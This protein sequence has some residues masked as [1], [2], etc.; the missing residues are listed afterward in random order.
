MS[1]KQSYKRVDTLE[2]KA[3]LTKRIGHHRADKYFDQLTRLIS[4]KTTKSEFDKSCARIVGRENIPL[5]NQLIR[6][7]IKNASLGKV[8]PPLG[9]IKRVPTTPN[10]KVLDRSSLQSLYGEAAFSPSTRKGRSPINRKFKDRPSPLG[11]LSSKPQN[12]LLSDEL[13]SRAQEQQQSATELLSLG[14]RP[15]PVDVASVEEGEEVEQFAGSPGVQSRCPVTAPF[16][17]SMNLGRKALS[18]LSLCGRATTNLHHGTCQN[19]GE[20]PDTRLLRNR[21]Q[22]K[23]QAEGMHVSL[24]CVNLLN[25]ALDAYLKRLVEPC[26]G[27]AACSRSRSGSFLHDAARSSRFTMQGSEGVSR[28]GSMLDFR[29]SAE[30]NPQMFGADWAVQLEKV[31]LRASEEW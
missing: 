13:I 30:S 9:S 18:N 8:P 1:S 16:G 19:S 11:P 26:L 28:S 17:I 27:L 2:I 25:N 21:L 15:P 23:L 22:Q 14:S 3:L 10:V 7:I 12:V 20:L 31:T 24:D 5:H 29:I 4:L 6:S